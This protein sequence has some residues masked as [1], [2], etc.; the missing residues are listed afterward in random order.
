M[1]KTIF[2]SLD[3]AKYKLLRRLK[4]KSKKTW[5]EFL[6]D[7]VLYAEKERNGVL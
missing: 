6:V 7:G 1:V 3:D 2:L 5:E 4:D